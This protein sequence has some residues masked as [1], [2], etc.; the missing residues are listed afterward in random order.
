MVGTAE[1]E[2]IIRVSCGAAV[3]ERVGVEG[4][5]CGVDVALSARRV[6]CG[7]LNVTVELVTLLRRKV[8]DGDPWQRPSMDTARALFGGAHGVAGH[9]FLSPLRV[10]LQALKG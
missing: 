7:M 2:D 1:G 9:A 4:R 6:D 8:A 3:D 5:C 10:F